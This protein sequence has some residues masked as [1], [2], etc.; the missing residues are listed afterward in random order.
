MDDLTP[1]E[2]TVLR[3]VHSAL[4]LRFGYALVVVPAKSTGAPTRAF[5]A[6]MVGDQIAATGLVH[7]ISREH[8]N[9]LWEPGDEDDQD[10][11]PETPA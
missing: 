6:I 11:P 1:E 8:I 4:R 9:S 7:C 5:R 2:H 10:E 3:N